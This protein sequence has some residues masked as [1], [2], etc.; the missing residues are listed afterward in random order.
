MT[1]GR[2]HREEGVDMNRSASILFGALLVVALL[3]GS[4]AAADWNFHGTA[5]GTWVDDD[6]CGTGVAVEHDSTDTFTF[7]AFQATARGEDVLTNLE[8]GDSIVGF[9]AGVVRGQFAGDP[10]GIHTFTFT[11]AGLP[12]M[13]KT[14]TGSVLIVNAGHVV[15]VVTWDGDEFISE[16]NTLAGRHDDAGHPDL[17][18]ELGVPALGIG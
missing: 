10:E 13:I 6:F 8:N 4:A 12:E 15:S 11:H 17:L 16:V 1:S 2:K 14:S 7:H 18:C 5:T 9:Y 3:P